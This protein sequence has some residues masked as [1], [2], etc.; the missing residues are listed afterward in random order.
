MVARRLPIPQ[1]DWR[2]D[3]PFRTSIG[4][5][6][7]SEVYVSSASIWEATIKAGIGKLDVDVHALVLQISKSGFQELPI[8]A[9]HAATHSAMV[10]HLPDLHRDPLDRI[11][12]AQA[13]CEPLRFL[14]A[15]EILQGYLN[16]LKSSSRS[17]GEHRIR[18][19]S[20]AKFATPGFAFQ[21]AGTAARK[22]LYVKLQTR[23]SV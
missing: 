9:T 12:I 23:L 16:W 11:L 1:P 17:W 7:A 19:K 10:A 6:A 4:R 13:L 2:T 18:K 3:S 15:D 14:T 5:V 21:C 20:G 8:S 22:Q